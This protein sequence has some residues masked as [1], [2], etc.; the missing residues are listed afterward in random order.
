MRFPQVIRKAGLLLV[1]LS[2][3]WQDGWGQ[4]PDPYEPR[5][6]LIGLYQ[7]A[8]PYKSTYTTNYDSL[9]YAYLRRWAEEGFNFVL[10]ESV[11]AN[12]GYDQAGNHNKGSGFLDAAHSLG[13]KVLLKAEEVKVARADGYR[14]TI[15]D[16]RLGD[17]RYDCYHQI[18][19]PMVAV[20]RDYF[21]DHPAV[22]GQ[23]LSDELYYHYWEPT[24]L[25]EVTDDTEMVGEFNTILENDPVAGSMMRYS[26]HLSMGAKHFRWLGQSLGD[27]S[28]YIVTG[29]GGDC[30]T[31]PP[32]LCSSKSANGLC[33]SCGTNYARLYH[34]IMGPNHAYYHNNFSF[35]SQAGDVMGGVEFTEYLDNF[36]KVGRANM[37]SFDE[38]PVDIVD[39]A[40]MYKKSNSGIISETPSPG[41]RPMV[42]ESYRQMALQSVL[43]GAPQYSV[44][45]PWKAGLIPGTAGTYNYVDSTSSGN[46]Y[47]ITKTAPLTDIGLW[48]YQFNQALAHGVK[49]FVYWTS[50]IITKLADTYWNP[51]NWQV[52]NWSDFGGYRGHAEMPLA[53]REWLTEVHMRLRRKQDILLNL[54]FAAAFHQT[55]E[56]GLVPGQH[57]FIPPEAML[58]DANLALDLT[59]NQYF[60]TR[61][62]DNGTPS[63]NSDDMMTLF[64]PTNANDPCIEHVM[65]STLRSTSGQHYFWVFNKDVHNAVDFNFQ[66][67]NDVS[68][69]DVFE[70]QVCESVNNEFEIHLEPGGAKLFEI[71]IPSPSALVECSPP[72]QSYQPYYPSIEFGD[73]CLTLN[74][75]PQT[76]I[77]GVASPCLNIFPSTYK[78]RFNA[79][80]IVLG[81]NLTV[82]KGA[83]IAFRALDI[84][85]NCGV[86]KMMHEPEGA[87]VEDYFTVHPNPT[88]GRITID[89]LGQEGTVSITNLNGKVILQNQ[90]LKAGSTEID[91][92]AYAKGV[93][94]ISVQTRE[95]RLFKKVVLM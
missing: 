25:D 75:V 2:L 83:D 35:G 7:Y 59:A 76:Q 32:G 58:T 43:S 37:L 40:G 10:C 62:C 66:L 47:Y 24:G 69:V 21:K 94:I 15:Y 22:I 64:L 71:G 60:Q 89:Y 52:L 87:P 34:D 90:P 51:N 84:T 6:F 80:E 23:V 72:L 44:I 31:T 5:E 92:S 13:M 8:D 17:P 9:S 36:Q 29:G 73:I 82:F 11:Y 18:N 95:K 45:N 1:F 88:N 48:N 49:G 55:D 41:M 12:G 42:F 4:Y 27:C 16:R 46:V 33:F 54:N 3:L 70:N 77:C 61:N 86:N 91:L 53:T 19:P 81:S 74:P 50:E 78:H 38:Y 28:D 79:E 68:M 30:N 39:V 26:N 85:P 65:V 63:D 20:A 93:Y 56:S 57:D 67:K 14:E